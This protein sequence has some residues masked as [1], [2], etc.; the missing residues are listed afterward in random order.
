MNE[1]FQ[2][3]SDGSCDLPPELTAKKQIRVIPFYV[4]FDGTN[5]R[6]EL[7]E[8]GI[9]EFYQEMVNRKGC[10]PDLPCPRCRIIWMRFCLMR[11]RVF[12]CWCC[13]F[14]PN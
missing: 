10:I 5:Y 13:A 14:P 4:S 7:E 2:I 3:I 6:K 9:R 1:Q 8:I 11:R 12:P